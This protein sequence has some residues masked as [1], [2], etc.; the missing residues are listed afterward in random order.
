MSFLAILLVSASIAG[1]FKIS[2][3]TE[4]GARE[5]A[6]EF[7][8]NFSQT[9]PFRQ[10][11][12]QGGVEIVTTPVVIRD[13]NCRGGAYDIARL[14]QC[15]LERADQACAG[16]SLCPVFTAVPNIGAGNQTRPISSG[17]YPWT[18]MLH[19]IGHSLGLTDEYVYPVE[20]APKYCGYSPW[21]NG[22]TVSVRNNYRSQRDAE[23]AC[24]EQV[25][26]CAAALAEGT[27]VTQRLPNGSFMIGTPPP[28]TG[29]PSVAL[30]VYAGGN[31]QTLNPNSTWRP[32]YC[33]TIMGHPDLSEA[34][35]PATRR[36]AILRRSPNLIPPYFQKL[37]FDHIVR[38]NR[39]RGMRFRPAPVEA[40]APDFRYRVPALDRARHPTETLANDCREEASAPTVEAVVRRVQELESINQKANFGCVR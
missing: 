32:Y 10:L 1:P 28:A 18:T 6:E 17:T 11:I 34:V 14:A 21:G 3:V 16:T 36:H 35:C 4:P 33:P 8:R 30:G 22:S 37:M 40:V 20:D 38:T 27:P 7:I 12:A 15:D 39:L 31:C 23:R 26:W 13:L 29:C 2:V 25:P 19:E 24:R 9:E 5:R